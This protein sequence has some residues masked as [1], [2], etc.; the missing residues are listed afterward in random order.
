MQT[1]TPIEYLKI[2]V[3]SHFGHDKETWDFRIQWFNNNEHMLL[4][5]LEDIS[6]GVHAADGHPV[7]KKAEAP[8]LLFA[9]ML[10][11]EQ[12]LEGKP[13][14][15]PISLDA[16]ASGAQILAVLIG[17]E[18]S[19]SLCNVIDTGDREDLYT[20]VYNIVR[21]ILSSGD[22]SLQPG[23]EV[24]I[25]GTGITR[26][27]C[28][29]AIMTSLYGSKAKPIEIFGEGV[30]LQAF[31]HAMETS[32]PGIWEL[33]KALLGLW[34]PDAYSND[35]VLPDNF[36]V[37]VKVMD[38]VEQT[39][40]FFNSPVTVTTTVNQPTEDGLSI[41]ANVTHSID[42][43]VVREMGRRCGYDQEKVNHLT[44]LLSSGAYWVTTKTRQQDYLL[45]TLIEHYDRTGF[46][47][48]RVLDLI[49]EENISWFKGAARDAL[50]DLVVSLPL[51]RFDVLS[52]HDCFRCHPN[53]GN[54]LRRQYNRILFDI[55][56]STLLED[57][58]GQ[59]TGEKLTV[60]KLGDF[61]QDILTANY[62]LS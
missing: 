33:N 39:V 54:D 1:F 61:A 50:E 59:I 36:H 23:D 22:F 40:Q 15:H 37:K 17:C 4:E 51:K 20:N 62:A 16:T 7:L 31:Y 34:Q 14:A 25:E 2:D 32:A 56:N 8:A 28:K 55:A 19:A 12:A 45:S 44:H 10:G 27:D 43:L 41:P 13:I 26:G 9:A 42:G 46:L 11:Y 57:I 47:S 18:K 49:D 52:V 29:Q 30:Q 48:A 24:Y 53:Y 6:V 35:W 38:K 3:A 60:Q 5:M 58:A 21:D